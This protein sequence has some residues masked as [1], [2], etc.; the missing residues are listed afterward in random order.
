MKNLKELKDS[1]ALKVEA[2]ERLTK[3]DNQT[4]EQV[5]EFDALVLSIEGL[6]N[7]IARAE[8]AEAIISKAAGASA[9]K[10]EKK[11]EAKAARG[12]SILKASREMV[13][14]KL[15][16]LEA[17]MHQEGQNEKSAS[18]L[19]GD[20]NA[21]SMP[22]FLVST[23]RALDVATEG[24]DLVETQK[25]SEIIPVLRPKL[26]TQ[27][28]GAR[29][30][31]GLVGDVDLGRNSAGTVATW[32]G[33]NDANAEST[34]TYDKLA[35]SANRLGA[36]TEISKQLMAQTSSSVE[37]M[38][39]EDLEFALAKALDAAAINGS[40]SGQ[41]TGILNTSGIGSVAMGTNGLA[42]TFAKIIDL[43]TEINTN[44]ADM[45]NLAYLT[46][47]GIAGKLKQTEKISSTGQFV[48]A[49]NELNGY[50]ANRST[51]VPSTLTKGSNNDCHAI[52]FGN[53]N[54]LIL[55]QWA[56]VDIVVDPYSLSKQSKIQLVINGWY[57]IAVRH[58]KSFAAIKDA[59]TA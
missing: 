56:G 2:L 17:E 29:V 3:V 50:S 46:T 59:R 55:A 1:R 18:G 31:S 6:D 33:E 25:A 20:A 42:P 45:G 57:D 9:S 28:L 27:A 51:Q 19:V 24:T 37:A 38:V 5:S 36:Y 34:P 53:W 21:F 12:Y 40:G 32:E 30:M 41:P 54:D 14:G 13:A 48:W 15:T 44:D 43:E 10:S 39:R 8:K 4:P 26:M 49:N 52:I 47:P 23:S 22:S 16:G 58:A 7:E 11:E 35:L